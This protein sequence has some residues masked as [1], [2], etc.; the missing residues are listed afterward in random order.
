MKRNEMTQEMLK[1]YCNYNSD[2]GIFTAKHSA[3]G[4]FLKAGRELG[5]LVNGYKAMHIKGVMFKLHQ[6][7]WLYVYG[8][9]PQ[10]PLQLD[11]IDKVK[12]NN[13]IS[14]LRVVTASQNQRNTG[15]NS[16]NTS[17]YK[18]VTFQKNRN[19]WRA[20]IMLDGINKHLGMFKDK[21]EAVLARKEAEIYYNYY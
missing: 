19:K 7:V 2:T 4:N 11:H 16:A 20:F 12:T 13:A 6:L 10:K 8:E 9:I 18:G 14:N 21:S 5:T 17:G 15:L 3:N 1:D